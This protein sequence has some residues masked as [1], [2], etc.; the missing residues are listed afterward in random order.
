MQG[1]LIDP[2]ADLLTRIRNAQQAQH[3]E[4]RLPHSRLKENIAKVFVQEG[5]LQGYRSEGSIPRKELVLELK[6][7]GREGV[8]E[9]MKRVSRPSCRHYV[10]ARD[11]PRVRN[12]LG[13][14]IMSTPQGVLTGSEARRR[15]V[16]GEV[17]CYVW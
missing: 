15:N 1:V 12:N 3:P 17:L 16:G 7:L 5:Y 2:V 6:Y 14:C 13:I 9:G 11:I 10:G 4:L 8:I